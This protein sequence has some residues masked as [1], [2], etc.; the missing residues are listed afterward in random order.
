MYPNDES[1]RVKDIQTWMVTI[2]FSKTSGTSTKKVYWYV[3]TFLHIIILAI[4]SKDLIQWLQG[5]IKLYSVNATIFNIGHILNKFS[6][7]RR[8]KCNTSML[9]S[10]YTTSSAKTNEI[11]FWLEP[12]NNRRK[13]EKIWCWT[14]SVLHFLCKRRGK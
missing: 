4:I 7:S 3:L 12:W 6:S 1:K 11:C 10:W 9:K 5:K 8:R 14:V 2:I 13:R